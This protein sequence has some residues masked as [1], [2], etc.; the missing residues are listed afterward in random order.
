MI[1]YH[2]TRF[3]LL[4]KMKENSIA[5]NDL[6]SLNN[7]FKTLS[8]ET[9]IEIL[10]LL[11]YRDKLNVREISH[12]LNKSESLISHQ[13]N[14]LKDNSLVNR[15]KFGKRVY[16]SLSSNDTRKILNLTSNHLRDS[17]NMYDI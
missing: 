5:D 3:Q 17:K 10:M 13:I 4:N 14:H 8:S 12:E 1:K 15:E 6:T 16:Y 2:N 7:F 11:S 9:R